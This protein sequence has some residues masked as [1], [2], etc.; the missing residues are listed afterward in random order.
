MYPSKIILFGEYLVLTG[1]NLLGTPLNMFSGSWSYGQQIDSRLKS[2]SDFI[3]RKKLL[4]INNRKFQEDISNNLT[5]KSNIPQGYGCG[6]SGALVAAVYDVYAQKSDSSL[7]QPR[8]SALESFYHGSSSGVDPILSLNNKTILFEES[9]N[10][11]LEDLCLEN[12]YL[13][14]SGQKRNADHYVPT[15]LNKMEDQEYANKINALKQISNKV[16]SL[17]ISKENF[18]KE[19]ISLSKMHLELFD[20]AIPRHINKI[21]KESMSKE[22]YFKICGAGGGGFFLVYSLKDIRSNKFIPL[23]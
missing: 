22:I 23:F 11:I 8:L 21:W 16:I 9:G 12:F 10:Q 6:S 14:D 3:S 4:F 20:F 13:F 2:L 5:F 18:L 7:I 19:Y 17:L 1:S 15:F